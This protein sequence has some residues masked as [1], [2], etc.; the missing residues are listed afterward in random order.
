MKRILK[1]IAAAG[2]LLLS[3]PAFAAFPERSITI[4]V[5][6][7][8]GGTNDGA[9]R[10]VAEEM[11]RL[12][13]QSIIVE[14]KA[15]AGGMIGAEYV[16]SSPPNGY[17]LFM[18]AGGHTVL[19][20]LHKTMRYDLIKDF[21]PIGMVC[22]S[23]YAV[24]VKS[25]SPARTLADLVK[26]MKADANPNYSSTGVGVLTHLAGEWLKQIS[27]I[28][29][30]H[31]PYKG[32]APS[33]TDLLGGHV[34]YSILSI[35]PILPHIK[36]NKLRPLAVTS[37]V[38]SPALPDVPTIAEALD[39][40]GFNVSTWFG[41]LAPAGTPDDVVSKLAETLDQ[42]LAIP[43]VRTK[44]AEQAMEVVHTSP[45]EFGEVIRRDVETGAR[46]ARS[47]GIQPE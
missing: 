26:V 31:V 39:E 10:V 43:A 25:S 5:A 20:N 30:T 34:D 21:E 16:A 2:L 14:N 40:P 19:P 47:I 15:G 32:D 4:V 9:A 35:T 42:V 46:I 37:D 38:R 23:G 28:S 18:A 24:V 12:L 13:G 41:L 8:A 7:P 33:L 3:I 1:N 29:A 45:Q 11:S 17:T 36:A 22:R 44:F 27:G 6:F